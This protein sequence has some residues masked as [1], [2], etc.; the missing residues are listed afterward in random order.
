MKD[1]DR[2]RSSARKC[3]GRSSDQFGKLYE[4]LG[5]ILV[6]PIFFVALLHL[7]KRPETA[8]FRWCISAHVGLCRAWD[9]QFS[10]CPIGRSAANLQ[11]NDLHVLFI[12]LMTFYGLALHPRDVV[13]AGDQHPPRAPRFSRPALSS[14]RR[15]PFIQQFLDLI[16]PPNGR[17]QWPPYVPPYIAIL[18]RMDDGEAR[19]SPRTCRGRWRGMPTAKASGCR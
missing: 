2:R 17:V 19:S 18:E 7:F 3:R 9:V 13:A 8:T 4:L 12:P 10:G 14:S 6:A 16:G 5:S 1:V 15:C 11:A